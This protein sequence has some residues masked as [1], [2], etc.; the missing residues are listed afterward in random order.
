MARALDCSIA[1]ISRMETGVR[2]LYPDD[3]SAILGF[4]QAPTQLREE[5]LTLVRD[6]RKPNLIQIGGKVPTAWK[7]LI[8]FENE[9]IAIFNYEPMVVP[10][11]LQTGDYA[12]AMTRAGDDELSEPEVDLLV[13]TRMGRQAVLS[14]Y[15]GPTLAVVMDEMVLR[16]PVG[17]PGVMQGQLQYLRNMAERPRIDLRVVPFS[18]GASPG[19]RGPFMILEFADQ[20]ALVHFDFPGATGLIEEA[21]VLRSVRLAWRK[22]HSMALSPEDSTRLIAEIAGEPT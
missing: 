21:P 16:R 22:L 5:L 10:G 6:G 12:R 1:K 9:T 15:Q 13:R 11:L 4:L 2:G 3:V 8:R 20:P 19:L 7:D 18:V 14:R 17:E